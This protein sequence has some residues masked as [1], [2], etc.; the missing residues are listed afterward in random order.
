MNPNKNNDPQGGK[1]VVREEACVVGN[2]IKSII[3][4]DDNMA[5]IS[6]IALYFLFYR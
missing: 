2:Q 5:T 1:W 6:T 3:R 4:C